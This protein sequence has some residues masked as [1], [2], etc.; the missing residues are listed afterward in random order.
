MVDGHK[1]GNDRIEAGTTE[2]QKMFFFL[3]KNRVFY[4]AKPKRKTPLL[5]PLAHPFNESNYYALS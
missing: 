2:Y 4:E 5:K 1:D 3:E